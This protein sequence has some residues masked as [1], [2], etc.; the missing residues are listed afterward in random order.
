MKIYLVKHE[1]YE[2]IF[3]LPPDVAVAFLVCLSSLLF[4]TEEAYDYSAISVRNVAILSQQT[5][6]ELGE[7]KGV[8]GGGVLLTVPTLLSTIVV[9]WYNVKHQMA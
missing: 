2:E 4:L 1:D 6:I 3:F 9:L 5:N 7:G 8:G